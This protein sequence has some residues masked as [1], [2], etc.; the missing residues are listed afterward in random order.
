MARELIKYT[1]EIQHAA[2]DD[3]ADI[4]EVMQKAEGRLFELSKTNIKKDFTQI[5]PVIHDAYEMLLAASLRT[6]GLSGLSSG[7]A[8]LDKVTSGWQNSD[9]IIIAA[10][11]A[12]GKTAFVLSMAK[13]MAIDQKIP[14]AMFSLEMANVQLVNRIISNVC[15]ISGAKLKSGQ[16]ANHEWAQLDYRINDMYDAPLYIDDT[17]SL[18]VFE[19]RT[20]ARR[21]V[22]DYGVKIIIIDYLQLMNA[23]GMSRGSC[24]ESPL[25]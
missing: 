19:L 1:A 22:R 18:S 7:F 2:F 6:D 21:L 25:R 4:H 13:N 9:L 17:P 15:E 10:R 23:S 20:K 8:S 11:P 14:V 16:L 5:N 3:S 24:Q 12:M